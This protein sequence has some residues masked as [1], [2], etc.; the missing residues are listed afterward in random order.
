MTPEEW[1]AQ[2]LDA[3]PVNLAIVFSDPCIMDFDPASLLP[4]ST[5]LIFSPP[6]EPSP[7]SH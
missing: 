1:R 4:S 5:E 7:P 3:P 2:Q 6:A